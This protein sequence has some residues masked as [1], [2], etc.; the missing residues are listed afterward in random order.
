MRKC[1][2]N[3]AEIVRLMTVLFCFG[4][5]ALVPVRVRAGLAEIPGMAYKVNATLADNLKALTGK[6]INVTLDSGSTFTGTV[7]AVGKGLLQLEK[8]EGKEYF[9]ALVRIDDISAIDTRFRDY[10]H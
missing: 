3:G 5:I 7:K 9:D 6:K 1:A 8:L 2:A 4:M 10:Q